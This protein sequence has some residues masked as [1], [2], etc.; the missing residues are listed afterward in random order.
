M[1]NIGKP[2]R[3]CL[4]DKIAA[5]ELSKSEL[6]KI[7]ED[8]MLHLET[9]LGTLENYP[10][11]MIIKKISEYY[12]E[13]IDLSFAEESTKKK[14]FAF[15][16]ELYLLMKNNV[17]INPGLAKMLQNF[18]KGREESHVLGFQQVII[19]ATPPLESEGQITL[20][21]IKRVIEEI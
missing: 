8:L 3:P 19:N 11:K 16:S 12:P 18:I 20:P 10:R 5:R 9:P 15:M 17:R 2:L 7:N 4:I 14:E 1:S 6:R 13:A 21:E